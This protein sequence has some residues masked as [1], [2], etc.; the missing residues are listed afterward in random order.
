MPADDFAYLGQLCE[1][2]DFVMCMHLH[3]IST[4]G[5]L[6]AGKSNLCEFC[7][8]IIRVYVVFAD[9]RFEL[10]RYGFLDVAVCCQH[11]GCCGPCPLGC[12]LGCN[13]SLSPIEAVGDIRAD[14]DLLFDCEVMWPRFSHTP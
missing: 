9:K 12:V 13:R 10:F 3:R 11:P 7:D 6:L 1:R 14:K 5:T 2:T 8:D 4:P